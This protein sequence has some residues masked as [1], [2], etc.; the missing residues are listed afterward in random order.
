MRN[1]SQ[2][3]RKLV[4]I[5]GGALGGAAIGGAL[6]LLGGSQANAASAKQAKLNREF[7]ERM[8][9]NKHQYEVADLRA[10]GLNPILSAHGGAAVPSGATAQQKNIVP[11]N[12]ASLVTAAL[13]AKADLKIKDQALTN[14]ELDADIKA[15][16]AFT[17]RNLT[18]AAEAAKTGIISQPHKPSALTPLFNDRIDPTNPDSVRKSL[19]HDVKN[20]LASGD[21]LSKDIRRQLMNLWNFLNK[22]PVAR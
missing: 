13:L 22:Q 18:S 7:Q 1:F 6:S 19:R 16:P 11:D 17:S 14:L 10:A 2:D 15:F 9:R 8:T 5:G 21:N 20:L 12:A 4:S 3:N